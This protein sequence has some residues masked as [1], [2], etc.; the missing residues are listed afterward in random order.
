MKLQQVQEYV[1]ALGENK[2][3]ISDGSHTFDELYFHRMIL[4]LS[5]LKEHP[6]LSWKS[7]KHSDGT[8]FDNYFIVGIKTKEGM[9][10]YHYRMI[11]WDYF[12][13]IKE[14]EFAPEWDGHKSKDVTRL[15][16]L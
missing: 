13:S 8:M 1:D 5:I 4:F 2:S 10:S 7:K 9:Y 15:L 6:D 14:V 12:K 3:F 11:Y 16:S